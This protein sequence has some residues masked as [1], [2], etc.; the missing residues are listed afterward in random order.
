[1]YT[2]CV[3][4][5]Q[6]GVCRQA[7]AHACTPTHHIHMCMQ[8]HTHTHCKRFILYQ[9]GTRHLQSF[10]TEAS[11]RG[12]GGSYA[13]HGT[14]NA[15][16]NNAFWPKCFVTC[17]S[18]HHARTEFS[19]S[20]DWQV[21]NVGFS[22]SQPSSLHTSSVLQWSS[23]HRIAGTGSVARWSVFVR[24]S[25][26]PLYVV[27]ARRADGSQAGIDNKKGCERREQC[28]HSTGIK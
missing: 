27:Y 2:C 12:G 21:L 7:R 5:F 16:R 8:K 11:L 9:Y 6:I 14:N 22:R 24:C 25:L 4:Q 18:S 17:R 28:L 15:K 13:K 10:G 1:M 3:L 19:Y 26:V 23:R 20:Q